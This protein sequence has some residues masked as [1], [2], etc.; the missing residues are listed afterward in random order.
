MTRA[1]SLAVSA[2]ACLLFTVLPLSA[3]NSTAGKNNKETSKVEAI[4]GTITMVLPDRNLVVVKTA[5]GA[6]F[7][8]DVNTRTRIES[9]GHSVALKD[10]KQDMNDNVSV[11]FKA[12]HRGDIARTIQ[13]NG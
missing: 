12:E 4:S 1:K 5:D 10:L 3:A 7:D 13:I 8:M 2:A 9:G 6:M 11:K